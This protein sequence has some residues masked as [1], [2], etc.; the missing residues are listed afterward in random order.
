MAA[1]KTLIG[2]L[3]VALLLGALLLGAVYWFALRP[4]WAAGAGALDGARDWASAVDLGEGITSDATFV[5]PADGRLTPAQVD[6]F[7]RIQSGL[8]TTLGGDLATL[9]ERLRAI[10]GPPSDLASLQAAA[11]AYA[12]VGD[13]LSRYKQAQ[14]SAVNAEGLS[15]EEFS[16]VR[17]QALTALPLL[18][19]LGEMPQ[20]P[21]LPDVPGLP[22]LPALP[23][24]P[25]LPTEPA[26]L[27][28]ARHNAE[29]LRPHLPLLIQTLGM[30]RVRPRP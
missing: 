15:R 10:Q 29:L 16:W 20:L 30:G 28:A 7:V 14:A 13:V 25:S 26:A 1:K 4:L 11:G 27:E 12:D 24:L 19:E 23:T 3:L 2:C 5:A 6:A 22:K 18:V 17:R 9:A 21:A 8:A